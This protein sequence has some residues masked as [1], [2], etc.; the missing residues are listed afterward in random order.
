MFRFLSQISLFLAKTW[1]VY[2]QRF[3]QPLSFFR[4]TFFIAASSKYYLG[5]SLAGGTLYWL[6]HHLS[7]GRNSEH[8]HDRM[9]NVH[10]RQQ[11]V[12]GTY[13]GKAKIG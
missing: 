12:C 5:V 10:V 1:K 3:P 11:R 6:G 9:G 8:V 13:S 4:I 7:A 2:S